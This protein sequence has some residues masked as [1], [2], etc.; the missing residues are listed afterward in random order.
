MPPAD[1]RA[2]SGKPPSLGRGRRPG[3]SWARRLA[4]FACAAAFAGFSVFLMLRLQ[5]GFSRRAAEPAAADQV[6]EEPEEV[7]SRTIELTQL[8]DRGRPLV[9]ISAEEALGRTDGIQRLLGVEVRLIEIYGGRDTVVA[10]DELIL[11]TRAESF[12]FLGNAL[13]S[14]EGLEL[15][16]PRLQFRRAPDRL[17]SSDPVQFRT[18]DFVGIAASL[19]FRI[20]SG[21]VILRGVVA[22]PVEAGGFS[23]IASSARFDRESAET[24][25]RGEIEIA[26]ER[27]QLS[28]EET[29]VL[30]RD[31]ERNRMRSLDAGFGT[32][33]RT[34]PAPPEGDAGTHPPSPEG[35]V[36][37]R[38]DEV[39]IDLEDGKTPRIVRVRRNPVLSSSAGELRGERGQLDL[40][41]DGSPERLQLSGEVTS[42]VEVGGAGR[43]RILVE[44]E[45][46]VADFDG[47]GGVAGARYRLGV[48]ARYG[49][50]SA[51]A[52][53][54]D[55][56]G[57]DTLT[58]SGA[59]RVVD[60]SLVEL[61]GGDMRL[62]VGEESRVEAEGEVTARFL[63][64]RLDWLPGRFDEVS[65]TSD[66]ATLE[67]G[68]GRG[69]FGGRVRL[70][71]GRNRLDSETLEVDAESRTLEAVGAV[72][73]SLEFESAASGEPVAAAAGVPAP[74]PNGESGG[75]TVGEAATA[76][77]PEAANRDFAFEVEAGRLRYDAERSR[78]SYGG[79][80]R[81]EQES[82]SAVS[83]VVAG[84]IEAELS[85][86][87]SVR[88]VTG[89]Q[90]A[91][92]ERG[93][94]EVRG[95]RIRYEPGADRLEAWGSPAVVSVE[96]RLSEGG[97]L[98]LD[99]AD[100]RSEI[101]PTRARRA[102]TR[103]RIGNPRR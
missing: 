51:S 87:G 59:P 85:P 46:M 70:L 7:V 78:L 18:E 93:S 86:D 38:G 8:D 89:D 71:F 58:L 40:A 10:A 31:R 53:A 27:L 13:L 37:F 91:R 19:Q 94:S 24:R 54:A 66:A 26:S 34:F 83:R 69:V 72:E 68:T 99:L 55:W 15:S 61:E 4:Q 41:D 65:L 77:E 102:L 17:W 90:G 5:E 88:A 64:D 11:N 9:E 75:A 96:G 103:A 28:S 29:V 50:A 20:D 76:A 43:S 21:A 48:L 30:R 82:G 3:G 79:S 62:V 95:G 100:D 52:D 56:N 84:R 22:G 101:L 63:P 39:E 47:R 33:L 14:T 45:E 57:E 32:E 97:H 49:R 2:R 60:S 74:E 81:L 36:R 98:E 35:G 23:V 67:S 44:A 6:P 80:P 42:R 1:L 73:S 92:F 16:G 12:E 25:L